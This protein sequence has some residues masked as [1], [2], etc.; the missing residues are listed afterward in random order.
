MKDA[1]PLTEM[2]ELLI[3]A[4][5]VHGLGPNTRLTANAAKVVGQALEWAGRMEGEVR[6]AWLSIEGHPAIDEC[7]AVLIRMIRQ[8][9]RNGV[10]RPPERPGDALFEGAGNFGSALHP[11]AL[12][13]FTSCRLTERGVSI[14]RDLLRRHPEYL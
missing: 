2:E 3:M 8:L 7:Y 14:A 6:K 10:H 13:H 11:P 12:P 4:A 5:A 9:L 1:V